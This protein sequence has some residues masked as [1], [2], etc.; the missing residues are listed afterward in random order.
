LIIAS[1]LAGVLG[2]IEQAG[3][4]LALRN[5]TLVYPIVN[6]VHIIGV[7]LLFGSIVALDLRLVGWRRDVGATDAFARLL[8]P[9][10]ITGLAVAIPAG[11]LLFATDARAYASS[12][13]FQAKIAVI[14]IAIANALWLRTT[15]WQGP[16]GGRRAALAGVAS[17]ALWLAAIVLGRLIGYF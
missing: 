1:T 11:L 12:P 3:P 16:H 13:L 8:L 9:V 17:I 5:S 15:D 7:A 4:V 10:A 2:A 14:A 6:A